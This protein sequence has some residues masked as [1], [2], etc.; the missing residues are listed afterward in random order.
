VAGKTAVLLVMTK[1]GYIFDQLEGGK[2]SKRAGL[3]YISRQFP[4][5]WLRV[6]QQGRFQE[7]LLCKYH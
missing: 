1:R 5:Y 3:F 7:N 6:W 2:S 4:T